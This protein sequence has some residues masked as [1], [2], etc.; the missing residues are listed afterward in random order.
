LSDEAYKSLVT[1]IKGGKRID[2]T[3]ANQISAGLRQWA[4]SKGVTIL[5]IGFSL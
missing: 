1:S 5:P 2:R 3:V 4:D